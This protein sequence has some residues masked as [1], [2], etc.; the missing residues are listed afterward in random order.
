[1]Q[2][3]RPILFIGLFL[4]GGL[5]VGGC[6]DSFVNTSPE[7]TETSAPSAATQ[8][9]RANGLGDCDTGVSPGGSIQEAVDAA[10]SGDVICVKPGTYAETISIDA[11]VTVRGQTPATSGNAAVI[12]GWV[13]LD[14]DGSALRR[15]VVTRDEPT[16]LPVDPFGIRITA[17]NTLVAGTVVHSISE[18]VKGGSINGIQAF[19]GDALS[20]ITIRDNVVR[21]YRNVDS[22]GNSV[23]GVAGIKVQADVSDVEV[24]SNEVRDLHSLFGF[25]VVLT[26]SSSADGFPK[27]VLVEGNTLEGINDGSVFDVFSGPN[28]GRNAAPF[29]GS[30]VA[31]EAEAE[32]ATVKHNNLLAP[33]GV[34]NKDEDPL[35]AKCNW[36]GDRSGPTDDDN[37]DGEGTWALER[38]AEIEYTPWLNASAPSTA[39]VGG[40]TPG[41]NRGGSGR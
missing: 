5:V 36:W 25:G 31:I 6:Q 7:E 17:S 11:S 29:P 9:Q 2:F 20:G 27:D 37:A 30:A 28:G 35:V 24:T 23:F 32:E 12:E 26:P 1:M 40:K 10:S 19:G 34:E 33:N 14:A 13:S 22:E 8:G 18:E 41:S 38:N 21:D 39:C 15:V 4:A 3:T 16:S